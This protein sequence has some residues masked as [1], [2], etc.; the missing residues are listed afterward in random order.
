MGSMIIG[1]NEIGIGASTVARCASSR[2]A[3]GLVGGNCE[4]DGSELRR[5]AHIDAREIPEDSVSLQGV[6]VLKD[7]DLLGLHGHLDGDAAAVGVGSPA[8]RVSATGLDA[9]HGRVVLADRPE[10][11][12]VLHVV[13]DVD[14][15]AAAAAGVGTVGGAVV[16]AAGGSG[17][18]ASIAS[19]QVGRKSRGE[20]A[21]GSKETESLGEL[22]CDL[23]CLKEGPL[24][25]SNF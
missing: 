15:A 11:D 3:I 12:G 5:S 19:E 14:T 16:A 9:D 18:V 7:I 21:K 4:A 8:L 1:R 6:L 22:H 24:K 10:V 2:R 20:S 25:E 13:H 17:A 23:I